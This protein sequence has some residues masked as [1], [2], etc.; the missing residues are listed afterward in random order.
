MGLLGVSSGQGFAVEDE[1]VKPLADSAVSVDGGL[2]RGVTWGD[3]DGDG[4]PDL[5]VAN[6]IGQLDFLYRNNRTE[7][8]PSSM[9]SPS[10]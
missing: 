9:K 4:Y 8:L 10:P 5:A 3:M 2:S 7:L 1:L 6:T